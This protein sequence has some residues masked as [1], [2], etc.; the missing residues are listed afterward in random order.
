[1]ATEGAIEVATEAAKINNSKTSSHK[2]IPTTRVGVGISIMEV[3][4]KAEAIKGI[5]IGSN[6]MEE[7]TFSSNSNLI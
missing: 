1:M 7:A 2:G 6:K 3:A 4:A 5:I